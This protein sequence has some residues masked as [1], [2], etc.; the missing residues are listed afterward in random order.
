MEFNVINVVLNIN[1]DNYF[2]LGLVLGLG[3]ALG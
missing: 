1:L 2:R 3:L